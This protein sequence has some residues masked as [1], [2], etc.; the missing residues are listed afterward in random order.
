M[1]HITRHAMKR[2]KERTGLSKRASRRNA[3]K[4]FREG[5][6]HKETSGALNRYITA[7]YF[8]HGTANNVRIYCGMIYIFC[9][10]VLVTVYPLPQKYRRTVERINAKRGRA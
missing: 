1:T 6:T 10:D 5:I 3:D 7:L 8:E 9:D 2:T 4:A